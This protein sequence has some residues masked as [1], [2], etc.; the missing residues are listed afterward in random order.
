M[1]PSSPIWRDPAPVLSVDAPGT[2]PKLVSWVHCT[3]E[4]QETIG[5]GF[6]SFQEART[7]YGKFHIGV[8]VS[9]EVRTAFCRWIPMR[10]TEVLYNTVDSDEILRDAAE[11]GGG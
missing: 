10:D 5:V 1:M 4:S 6:R 3:M 11:P 2:G 8:F 9:Q 7:C